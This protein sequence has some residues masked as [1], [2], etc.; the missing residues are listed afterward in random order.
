MSNAGY[1]FTRKAV[2]GRVSKE[3]STAVLM[4]NIIMTCGAG[5]GLN[6][7]LRSILNRGDNVIASIPYFVEYKF[8]CIKLRRGNQVCQ[9]KG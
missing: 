8:L 5:G 3:Q 1:D 4:D 7:I 6:V 2:A 9:I